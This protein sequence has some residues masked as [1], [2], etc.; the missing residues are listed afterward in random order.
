MCVDKQVIVTP[1]WSGYEF[2]LKQL[3]WLPSCIFLH[4]LSG[5]S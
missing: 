5:S 3:R 1:V 2:L 4:T